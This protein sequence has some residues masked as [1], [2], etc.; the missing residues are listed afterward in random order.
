VSASAVCLSAFDFIR[1]APAPFVPTEQHAQR[2]A[3]RH[4]EVLGFQG[5]AKR[6]PV[7]VARN[8]WERRGG[9]GRINGGLGSHQ[10]R[11]RYGSQA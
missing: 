9:W 6:R 11:P 5:F 8:A 1:S 4:G 2:A 3:D 10:A 7:G